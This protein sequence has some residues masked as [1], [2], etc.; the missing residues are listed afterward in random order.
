MSRDLS[1][2][3][4]S[5]EKQNVH[6][7]NQIHKRGKWKNIKKQASELYQEPWQTPMTEQLTIFAKTL[8]H[9]FLTEF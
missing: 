4:L 1:S 3:A 9:R 8:H 2:C 6:M 5:E 7:F